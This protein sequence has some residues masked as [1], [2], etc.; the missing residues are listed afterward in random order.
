MKLE[1]PLAVGLLAFGCLL[2][3]GQRWNRANDTVL[4]SSP[5]QT[6]HPIPGHSAAVQLAAFDQPLQPD[7]STQQPVSTHRIGLTTRQQAAQKSPSNDVQFIDEKHFDSQSRKVLQTAVDNLFNSPAITAKSRIRT[8]LFGELVTAEGQLV[9]L[10]QGTNRSRFEFYSGDAGSVIQIVQI[11]D[12]QVSYVIK[13]VN[14]QSTLELIDLY[15]LAEKTNS[16]TKFAGTASAWLATG[17]LT[18][19][20]DHLA[21]SFDFNTPQKT[22]ID[23]IPMLTIRGQWRLGRLQQLLQ[24][25]VNLDGA[26]STVR[27]DQLPPQLPHAVEIIL[28]NDEFMPLFPYQIVFYQYQPDGQA[29]PLVS[30]EMYEVDKVESIDPSLFTVNSNNIDSSINATSRYE[31]QIE[32]YQHM[33]KLNRENVRQADANTQSTDNR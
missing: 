9:H 22:Q 25:Q 4:E 2:C 27:W 3:L 7:A 15:R 16:D 29:R 21:R 5:S 20:L 30:M 32:F 6:K 12:G 13:T 14:G 26:Q 8:R 19:L 31:N 33:A 17:G 18:S 23:G 24:G 28:G 10:G 1:L 11:C